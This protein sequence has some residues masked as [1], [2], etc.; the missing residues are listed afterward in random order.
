MASEDDLDL[1]WTLRWQELSHQ[2]RSRLACPVCKT[3]HEAGVEC[4]SPLKE[5]L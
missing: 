5:Y 1:W 2:A 4:L 3:W